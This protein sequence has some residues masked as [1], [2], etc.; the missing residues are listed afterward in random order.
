MADKMTPAQ[1]EAINRR[2]GELFGL[3]AMGPFLKRAQ[4]T[5]PKHIAAARAKVQAFDRTRLL[6]STAIQEFFRAE[7]SKHRDAIAFMEPKDAWAYVQKLK[8]VTASQVDAAVQ[9]ALKP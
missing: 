7:A 8:P 5:E 4:G 2:S 6:Y 3:P 1:R 9:K